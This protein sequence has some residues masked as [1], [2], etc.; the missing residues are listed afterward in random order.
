MPEM[1]PQPNPPDPTQPSRRDEDWARLA[2]FDFLKE[3]TTEK[4]HEI[5]RDTK[6]KRVNWVADAE[7]R[8]DARTLLEALHDCPED[9]LEHGNPAVPF[10]GL[11]LAHQTLARNI[12][13]WYEKTANGHLK[14]QDGSK[15]KLREGAERFKLPEVCRRSPSCTCV[16]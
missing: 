5:F 4:L 8:L 13:A 12:F 3:E 11:K 6:F 9:C 10:A 7:P 15:S 16:C 14:K 1:R 2:S